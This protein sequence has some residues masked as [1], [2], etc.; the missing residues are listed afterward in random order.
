M[1]QDKSARQIKAGKRK[2]TNHKSYTKNPLHRLDNTPIGR[3]L[4][5]EDKYLP[6]W[7]SMKKNKKRRVVVIDKNSKNELAVVKLSSEPRSSRGEKFPNKTR[8]PKYTERN[9]NKEKDSYFKHFVEIEDNEKKPIKVNEK[10]RVNP[11]NMDVDI[12]EVNKIRKTIFSKARAKQRNKK[13]HD[14]FKKK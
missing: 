11:K 3:T 6:G 8:L 13:I 7:K 12:E 1:S 4:S 9:K 14:D 2:K 10:F 5:T